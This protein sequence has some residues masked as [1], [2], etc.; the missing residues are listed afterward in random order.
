VWHLGPDPCPQDSTEVRS[1]AMPHGQ[2]RN[3]IL[4]LAGAPRRRD[5]APALAAS[6]PSF[7]ASANRSAGL[8]DPNFVSSLPFFASALSSPTTSQPFFSRSP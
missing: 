5:S 1:K 8:A 2:P 6:P 3:G 7:A 4:S